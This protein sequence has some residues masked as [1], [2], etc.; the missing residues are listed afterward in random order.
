[1]LFIDAFVSTVSLS[2]IAL[3]AIL[4]DTAITVRA[5]AEWAGRRLVE[6]TAEPAKHEVRGGDE[7]AVI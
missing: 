5:S 2:L 7:F 6:S 3:P 4:A 1:M